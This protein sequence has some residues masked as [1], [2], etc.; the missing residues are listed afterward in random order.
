MPVREFTD[1][2]GV[3]WHAWEITPDAI[4]PPTRGEDYLA[5]CY[6]LGWVV[7]ETK[8]GDR[9]VRLCPI[10]RDWHRLPDR[11]LEAL[12]GAG[13]TL[14]AREPAFR[15]GAVDIS[16]IRSFR[17]PDGRVWT[18]SVIPHPT[19]SGNR[20]LRFSAGGRVI[21]LES[22]PTNWADLEDDQLVA[23]L[24]NSSPRDSVLKTASGAQRRWNDRR[25]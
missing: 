21:D 15:T 1:S 8:S 5:E 9:R 23:L 14:P 16:L 3:E 11:D 13:E 7:L 4:Y 17:Y 25:P 12:A 20:V 2:S 10:P 18:V 6:Q 24:R 19:T 22:W